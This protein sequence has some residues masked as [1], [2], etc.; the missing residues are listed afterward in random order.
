MELLDKV[1]S[2][3]KQ[4]N[5]AYQVLGERIW[6]VEGTIISVVDGIVVFRTK[7]MDLPK[8]KEAELCKQLLEWNAYDLI[9]GAYALEGNSIV[10][11]DTLQAE[12]LDLNEFVASYESIEMTLVAHYATLSNYQ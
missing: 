7:I 5:K 1:E 10:I 4:M 3:I 6:E 8:Q 2:Y 11:V 9:H 12:N